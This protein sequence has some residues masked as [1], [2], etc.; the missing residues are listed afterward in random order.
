MENAED[1]KGLRQAWFG[2]VDPGDVGDRGCDGWS[3]EAAHGGWGVVADAGVAVVVV[4]VVEEVVGEGS[5]VGEAGESLRESGCV[6]EGL[7]L[8]F[9]VGVVVGAVRSAVGAGDAEVGEELGDGSRGH[10]AAAVGDPTVRTAAGSY[11]LN[12]STTVRQRDSFV[13]LLSVTGGGT[14]QRLGDEPWGPA[15]ALLATDE[16]DLSANASG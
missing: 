4:V 13:L 1:V 8:G 9:G 7:E 12:T 15:P 11:V 10:G 6:L 2:L 3:S 16:S 5:G 14:L